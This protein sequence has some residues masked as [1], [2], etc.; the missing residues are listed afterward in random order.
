MSS[1]LWWRLPHFDCSLLALIRQW[2]WLTTMIYIIKVACDWSILILPVPLFHC[3][4][5]KFFPQWSAVVP[6]SCCCVFYCGHPHFT[7]FNSTIPVDVI[8]VR[9]YTWIAPSTLCV[10]QWGYQ[11]INFTLFQMWLVS[12]VCSETVE[13]WALASQISQWCSLIL[14]YIDVPVLLM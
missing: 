10:Y 12:W 3:S 1:H 8:R 14:S 7:N 2:G 4:G 6:F 9:S 13:V 5:V 11:S